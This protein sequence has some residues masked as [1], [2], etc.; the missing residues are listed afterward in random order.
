MRSP[1]VT[2]D[3]DSLRV[4]ISRV[5]D[6]AVLRPLPAHISPCNRRGDP[7]RNPE[8]PIRHWYRR[9]PG[10]RE[11]YFVFYTRPCRWARCSFCVL[12][13]LSATKAPLHRQILRQAEWVVEQL[14]EDAPSAVRRVVLSNNGSVLDQATFSSAALHDVLRVC[15]NRFPN[16][17]FVEV[18]TRTEFIGDMRLMQI[19][20]V[21]G[22]LHA[23]FSATGA[24]PRR[25]PAP[26]ILQIN[27]GYET[28]DPYLR[29]SVLCKGYGERQ[30][31]NFFAL[32]GGVSRASGTPIWIDENVML[33]PAAGLTD[34]DAIAEAVETIAHLAELG[35]EFQVPISVRLNPTFAAHGS[36]LE[37]QFRQ[38]MYYPPSLRNVVSVL[39]ACAVRGV[40]LPIFVGLD[41]EGFA[42][43]VATFANG[44]GTDS[45]YRS[46]LEA[47]NEHQS[48]VAL[49]R[50][51]E[52]VDLAPRP[53]TFPAT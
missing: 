33:K 17:R 23:E 12:P 40:A 27:S 11:V 44:D 6:R 51:L 21:L 14:S 50:E 4:P 16:L 47:F 45:T 42:T 30:V 49:R 28:Q 46:A 53:S 29:N 19:Q 13:S 18:E 34:E 3:D 10:G 48:L 32:V 37:E 39:N 43:D 15:H 31:Q 5:I 26:A 41:N 24:L 7:N 9:I 8:R 52:C 20:T 2:D 35:R 38:Q 25:A 1:C 36:V 22:R